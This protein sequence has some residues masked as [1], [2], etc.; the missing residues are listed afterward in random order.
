[1]D[2]GTYGPKMDKGN[3]GRI[4]LESGRCV[5]GRLKEAFGT[6]SLDANFVFS[7]GCNAFMR[8]QY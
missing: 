2:F 6:T 4:D 3:D 1:M 7:L 5:D 8:I